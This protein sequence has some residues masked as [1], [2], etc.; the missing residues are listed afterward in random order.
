[1]S[2]EAPAVARRRLRLALRHLREESQLTQGEV[3]KNLEWSLSKV[4]RIEIGDVTVSNTDLRALLALFHVSDDAR[5]ETLA[6]HCRAARRR[7]WWDESRY[8]GLLTPATIELLQLQGEAKKIHYFNLALLPGLIQTRAYA[9]QVLAFW[10]KELSEAE[11]KARIDVR[12]RW[13]SHVFDRPD[14]PHCVLMLDESIFEREV[15]GPH[16]MIEQLRELVRIGK[17]PH[18]E[19]RVVPL[20]G[21]AF[22]AAAAPF[23]L[24]DLGDGDAILY[25]ETH[26]TDGLIDTPSVVARYQQVIGQVLNT[27]LSVDASARFIEARVAA[28]LS[29]LDRR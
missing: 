27:A 20:R 29:S 2:S 17:Q 1:M 13:Q 9:E 18:V 26:L 11:R 10:S 3:A 12:M 21:S 22:V 25:R 8:R 6:E 23:T 7:A 14:P 19:L 5:I 15:G 24:V 4:N 16:V 28:L